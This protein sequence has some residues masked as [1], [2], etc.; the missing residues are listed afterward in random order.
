MNI[1]RA[2]AA[3]GLS[4]DTIRFYERRG[5]L[6]PPPR[7]PN[8]YRDYSEQHV[9]TLRLAVGL[10]TL[11]LTLSEMSAVLALAHDGTC[12]DVRT[13]LGRTL[14]GALDQL[15]D[16]IEELARSREQIATIVA[17]LGRMRPGE[18]LVPGMTPCACVVLVEERAV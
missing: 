9:E 10:R 16:R 14:A 8:R 11:G 6:P 15:D 12:R 4:S 7:R 2:A 13:V 1:Q 3:S 5:V 18:D 17:G